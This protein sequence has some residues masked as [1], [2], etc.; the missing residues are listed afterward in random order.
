MRQGIARII[1]HYDAALSIFTESPNLAKNLAQRYDDGILLPL[2]KKNE[3]Q[4]GSH[5][6]TRPDG[7]FACIGIGAGF[8]LLHQLQPCPAY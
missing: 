3:R 8:I 1:G 6:L 5:L 7:D 4:L 2:G